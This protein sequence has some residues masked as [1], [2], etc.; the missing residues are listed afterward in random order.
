MVDKD[1]SSDQQ[2]VSGL[3]NLFSEVEDFFDENTDLL[4]DLKES[5]EQ[6]TDK[7]LFAEGGMKR[8]FKCRDQRTDRYVAM[9]EVKGAPTR[10]ILND[11]L[12]EARINSYLQ[13]PNIVPIYEISLNEQKLPFFTMK[14]VS[15]KNLKD[16]LLQKTT[17]LSKLLTLYRKVCEAVAYAHSKGILHLDIK[18]E[19][20]SV[21]DYGEVL[22]C[23]WG[24]SELCPEAID[25]EILDSEEFQH[26]LPL[27]KSNQ[28]AGGSKDYM[29]PEITEPK[30]GQKSPAA[31]IYSLGVLLTE[32]LTGPPLKASEDKCIPRSLTAIAAKASQIEISQRYRSVNDILNELE[33]YT[34]GYAT[35]AEEASA[36]VLMKLVYQRNKPICLTVFMALVLVGVLTNYTFR[37][38][39]LSEQKAVEQRNEAVSAKNTAMSLL[40]KLKSEQL[41][42]EEMATTAALR[43]IKAARDN[44]Y[45]KNYSQLSE[46]MLTAWQ[47]G[48][49]NE[50]VRRFYGYYQLSQLKYRQAIKTLK[51]SEHENHLEIIK[52]AS[53]KV[54]LRLIY[55]LADIIQF[56][57]KDKNLAGYFLRNCQEYEFSLED[58]LKILN[59]EMETNSH[60]K[61]QFKYTLDEVGLKLDLSGSHFGYA[62][63]LDKFNIYSINFSDSKIRRTDHFP[64]QT[65][66]EVN[67]SNCP[68][69][70][71]DGGIHLRKLILT[72]CPLNHFGIFKTMI[73]L[74]HLDIRGVNKFPVNKLLSLPKLQ[75]V[76]MDRKKMTPELQKQTQFKIEFN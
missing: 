36:L 57:L 34:K 25:G 49:H 56:D 30:L 24:I 9:A 11:F 18:P 50:Q 6:Y 48:E 43:Y 47:L 58:K 16:I 28:F 53:E 42:K 3:R 52:E 27:I 60:S 40:N 38:I 22:L 26:L 8:I 74:E 20:I 65:L 41:A 21:S 67:F 39:R 5:K 75:L 32:I 35:E 76:K 66:R 15:G 29:A 54:E 64:W 44:L 31:D 73:N 55:A 10:E 14:L 23:D 61:L 68:I 72:N 71:L 46:N 62:A 33:Q 45:F 69:T 17:S 4:Q 51:G 7:T 63:S 2:L 37:K 19:N 12:R 1:I 70:K 59:R 13:H